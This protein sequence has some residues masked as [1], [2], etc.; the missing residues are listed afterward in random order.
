MVWTLN[1]SVSAAGKGPSLRMYQDGMRVAV[2]DVVIPQQWTTGANG[3]TDVC[4]YHV[5]QAG[6]LGSEPGANWP[7]AAEG[8]TGIAC[9]SAIL[10]SAAL[11]HFDFSASA[12]GDG[13]Q[14]SPFNT[15]TARNTTLVSSN[16]RIGLVR[17]GTQQTSSTALNVGGSPTT[18]NK[19]S[20]IAT[21]YTSQADLSA[22]MP[23]VRVAQDNS[24][25]FVIDRLRSDGEFGGALGNGFSFNLGAGV[26]LSEGYARRCIARA[27]VGTGGN[28]NGWM[29]TSPN[30]AALECVGL[31]LEYCEAHGCG[32]YGFGFESWNTTQNAVDSSVLW[33]CK[34]I[35]N[36]LAKTSWGLGG[37]ARFANNSGTAWSRVGGVG[38][39]IYS[40]SDAS[41]VR[42][43]AIH[44]GVNFQQVTQN[45]G[46]PT[47]P[48]VGEWGQSAGVL[49]LNLGVDAGATLGTAYSVWR[50]YNWCDGVRVVECELAEQH[51]A[52]GS[53]AGAD[54]LTGGWIFERNLTH[55]ND[56]EGFVSNIA[57]GTIIRSNISRHDCAVYTSKAAIT[58]NNGTGLTAVH[59]TIEDCAGDGISGT[60]PNHAVTVRNNKVLRV[61]GDG[62]VTSGFHGS[63]V[64]TPNSMIEAVETGVYLGGKDFYRK[65]FQAPPTMGAVQ[66][67]P[68]RALVSSR[69]LAFRRAMA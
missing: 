49:Y 25:Y 19:W 22:G 24:R 65:E 16:G 28:N 15:T 39:F 18:S 27:V 42:R 68:P 50:S 40:F 63:S 67:Q 1:Q 47:T 41:T 13:S 53:G 5:T 14:T 60:C 35:G 55:D 59:N 44:G 21:Y 52:D 12:D 2:G 61:A 43:M 64:T 32:G 33:R 66:Y 8:T 11:Y 17:Y 9:G 69:E 46:T 26:Q 30:A 3:A 4:A 54:T 56:G 6:N 38:T 48:G 51:S 57:L 20:W 7:Y 23:K 31:W 10:R 36:G 34:A 29:F 62:I 58:L 45:T 37:Y